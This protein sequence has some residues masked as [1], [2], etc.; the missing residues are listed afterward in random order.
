MR[1]ELYVAR[2][3]LR[4]DRFDATIA[5]IDH[6]LKLY[7][8]SALEAE[9]LVLKGETLL[10]M[11]KPAD[12]RAVFQKVIDAYGGPFAVSARRFIADIDAEKRP[13]KGS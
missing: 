5:R 2:F 1:H 13:A 4:E 7:P 6:A 11:N 8:G 10:K 9:A 3:Y 12:A